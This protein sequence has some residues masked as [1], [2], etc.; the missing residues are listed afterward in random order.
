MKLINLVLIVALIVILVNIASNK[1]DDKV[2][3]A[4][5]NV[6]KPGKQKDIVIS[7]N[8]VKKIVEEDILIENR[9]IPVNGV[10]PVNKL[11]E[12]PVPQTTTLSKSLSPNVPEDLSIITQGAT[13]NN[14]PIVIETRNTGLPE[15]ERYFPKYYR[16][17]NISGNTNGTGEYHLAE[18]SN[19]NSS[20]SWSD[21]NVSQY[22]TYYTSEFKDNLTNVGA[23]FDKNNQFVD[24]TKPRSVA[25]V[26]D[27]CYTS[28]EGEKVCLDNKHL[29]NIPPSLIDDV[30]SCGFLNSI[31]LL[32]FSNMVNETGER[33]NNGGLLYDNVRGSKKYNEVYSKP[34]QPELLTCQL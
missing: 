13:I 14:S 11:G 22:P 29:Q 1:S 9:G 34:L 8:G 25:N 21:Q 20:Y 18:V 26:D 17:D 30:N 33:V 2:K 5:N 15:N 24:T 3:V 19:L 7:N 27:V 10:I 31:G 12:F 28:K 16:K 23:F 4:L 6:M 32:E